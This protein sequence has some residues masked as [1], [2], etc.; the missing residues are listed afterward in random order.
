MVASA[1]SSSVSLNAA[2]L[3]NSG[4][5]DE[6][7]R[8]VHDHRAEGGRGEGGEERTEGEHGQH[9]RGHGD[10]AGEL[11]PSA[12]RVPD[13]RAAAAAAHREAVHQSRGEVRGTQRQQLPL[14]VDA[15]VPAVREG[16]PGQDVVGVGHERDAQRRRH[17]GQRPAQGHVRQG[18]DR[19][20][21]G[22][23]ADD[24]DPL[25]AQVE[26]R[27]RRRGADHADQ[28]HRGAGSHGAADQQDD[29]GDQP[30]RERRGVHRPEMARHVV[31]LGPEAVRRHV[32]P[33]ELAELGDDHQH[34]DPG[35]VADE[36]RAGQQLGEEGQPREP[37]EQA[38]RRHH[39]AQGGGE[40]GVALRPGRGQGSHGR[41]GHQGGGRLGTD[42]ELAR[43]AQGGVRE[44]RA[45][46]RPQPDDRRE[47]GHLGVGHHLGDEVR[48]DG[49]AREEVSRAASRV[50]N[51]RSTPE[52]EPAGP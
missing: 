43:G 15:F 19:K 12:H 31:E 24:G 38:Q 2:S 7:Q 47:P 40:V 5:V 42:R 10:H 1:I 48:R 46:R 21:G 30:E 14:G 18:G 9:R 16:P 13:G 28:G 8:G 52:W 25:A 3:R 35:H 17:Q 39:E 29:Q 50:G 32:D 20:P 22:D 11:G 34:R 45:D 27:H 26:Q 4:D 33:G 37:A 49:H 23:G 6:P 41:R 36:H 51:P 44:E